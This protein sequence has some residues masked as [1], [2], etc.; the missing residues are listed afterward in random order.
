MAEGNAGKMFT[1]LT[2]LA[3][4]ASL[5]GGVLI[6]AQINPPDFLSP[7]GERLQALDQPALVLGAAVLVPLALAVAAYISSLRGYAARRPSRRLYVLNFSVLWLVAA[8]ISTGIDDFYITPIVPAI[9]AVA[10]IVLSFT[11]RLAEILIG[12]LSI[13][14]GDALLKAEKW[15]LASSVLG[16]A[17]RFNPSNQQA[18][19][20]QGLALYQLGEAA[21]ALE[22]LVD[23]Y[24][25]GD[26]DPRLVRLLA[27]SVFELPEDL[28]S[29]VLSDAL[30]LEPN[31]ARFGRKLV[32]LHLRQ[33]R[34]AEAIPVLEKFYDSDN[35]EDVCLLGR[36]N[37]EQ[38]NVERALQLARRAAELEGPPYRRTL[39]DLQ[40]LA[41]QAPDSPAVLLTL[42]EL[43]E[44]VGNLDES[45]SWYLNLLDV[46][47]KNSDARRR[48]ISIYRSL[49][50]IDR[51]LPHYRTLLRHE[52]D[53]P[54]LALEYGQL[55]E[56]REEFDKALKIY[57]DFTLRCPQDYRFAYRSAVCLLRMGKLAEAAEALERARA[58][59]PAEERG[60]IQSLSTRI[61]SARAERELGSLKEKAH[62]P[63]APLQVRLE[64]VERLIDYQQPEEATRE[65][66]LLLEEQPQHKQEIVGFLERVIRQGQAHFV[67]L[68]MLAD[69][70]L[71][72]G[73][74]DR[75][76]ELYQMMAQQSLHPDEILADGCRQILRRKP[77]HLPSL[78]SHASLLAKAGHYHEAAGVLEKIL[79][80]SPESRDQLL[81]TLFEVYYHLGDTER[82]VPCGEQLLK[83][84]RHNLALHLRLHELFTKRD[85]HRSAIRILERALEIDPDNRQLRDM[86]KR[87]QMALKETRL[88]ALRGRLEADPDQPALLREM[89]DLYVDFGRLNDAITAYQR[90]AQNAEGNL[91]NL[92]LTRLA[93]CLAS[94]MMF[95]LADETLRD[96]D[97]REKDQEYI[98][99]IKHYLYEVGEL[100]ELDEQF[101]RALQIYKKLFKI[102]AGYRDVVGKIEALSHYAR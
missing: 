64:Y 1:A 41:M 92:C 82:A 94:K 75:C 83:R 33:G 90:A 55:L 99:E 16:V 40:V 73:N 27:D 22:I 77:D 67:L 2:V 20:D 35:L 80:I 29:E 13:L 57:Q 17:R 47:P 45:A 51:A 19:R 44:R 9:T 12:R 6:V 95:D 48:L 70:Y 18:V 23:A 84:D 28:A 46:Q 21:Q 30:K 38:G 98:E 5:A 85:D 93:H 11:L 74:F 3:F 62:S 89:A 34:A 14:V 63:D 91:R 60:R 52:P 87:S 61:Q 8:Y 43:N 66:D 88:E 96:I 69:I 36:L 25:R 86:L 71:R 72:D 102:D 37:A 68:N 4:L 15:A 56:E 100:F 42:A 26:R 10:L 58:N 59:A 50:R 79:E 32:E 39:A 53:S 97:V 54:D 78:M 49:D 24:R 7:L 81:P 101:D 31:N 76:H 65:L